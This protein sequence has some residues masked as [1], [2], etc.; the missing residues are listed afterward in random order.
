MVVVIYLFGLLVV[1][2]LV[3]IV[4]GWWLLCVV[5]NCH[6]VVVWFVQFYF[7][8]AMASAASEISLYLTLMWLS[9]LFWMLVW[10]WLFSCLLCLVVCCLLCLVVWNWLLVLCF[11]N[12]GGGIQNISL[13]DILWRCVADITPAA[14]RRHHQQ[15]FISHIFFL[16]L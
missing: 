13:L 11:S 7:P 14:R 15:C 9:G 16:A 8:T 10:C 6:G 5:V 4:D 2:F 1:W 3:V 12:R